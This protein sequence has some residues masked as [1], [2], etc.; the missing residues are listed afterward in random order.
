MSER[1]IGYDKEARHQ[2]AMVSL[3]DDSLPTAS[4]FPE[5]KDEELRSVES[6]E[7]VDEEP[8]LSRTTPK[9]SE[10]TPHTL[11][12][13]V[14]MHSQPRPFS[15]GSLPSQQASQI[16]SSCNAATAQT[17]RRRAQPQHFPSLVATSSS[18]PSHSNSNL[19]FLN[20]TIEE[21]SEEED[22]NGGLRSSLDAGMAAVRRWIR[23][24][25][26]SSAASS[27]LSND[28]LN[29]NY[30]NFGLGPHQYDPSETEEFL[31]SSQPHMLMMT[32]S[33][34]TISEDG[35]GTY[36]S[37]DENYS[38][39]DG[40]QTD[41]PRLRSSP[42]Q[43]ALS[44]PDA[45]RIREVLFQRALNAPQRGGFRRRRNPSSSSSR[46]SS[47]R[48]RSQSETIEMTL[49]SSPLSSSA[50]DALYTTNRS[51]I[52]SSTDDTV[53]DD[54]DLV[55]L[56]IGTAEP[57]TS[58]VADHM[59]PV[60]GVE[61]APHR[62][63]SQAVAG[64]DSSGPLNISVD[65]GGN[66]GGDDNGESTQQARARWIAINHRF[67]MIITVVAI[68]F[69]LLLF[70]ILVC[71]VVLTSAYVVSIDK[72]CDVPLK[73]SIIFIRSTFHHFGRDETM[74]SRA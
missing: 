35:T 47:S 37:G 2:T 57:T 63:D 18:P 51:S 25:T 48:R 65:S 10:M 74:S 6:S 40:L 42:R 3:N 9:I 19:H 30:N 31:N 4:S 11:P 36:Y 66:G 27:S 62:S 38:D 5:E 24:R 14:D 61:M 55:E 52:R 41:N 34:P 64:G 20:E 54:T 8:N 32:R 53:L 67:Q 45:S 23:S 29:N 49:S 70:S 71:W 15:E 56:N 16:L 50:A 28:N 60:S 43:R 72:S 58:P 33:P 13:H 26:S 17:R 21:E 1:T 44:E 22:G 46:H 68:I 59:V 39:C 73:V 69:S 12:Q 7:A